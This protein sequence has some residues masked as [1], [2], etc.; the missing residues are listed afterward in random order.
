MAA[1]F[2]T[3]VGGLAFS[4]YSLLVAQLERD[5]K[6]TALREEKDAREIS[7]NVQRFLTE[8]LLAP[9]P[10]R[11]G[12]DTTIREAL[13][14]AAT[15]VGERFAQRPKIE[16]ELRK[17][18]GQ[19]YTTLL[20][21]EKAEVETT[22]QLA[23]CRQLY[24]DDQ[25]ETLE[26]LYSLSF[27]HLQLNQAEL[28]VQESRTTLAGFESCLAPDDPR[29][30][31]A[32]SNLGLAYLRLGKFAEGEREFLKAIDLRS[33]FDGADTK[34]VLLWKIN[35]AYLYVDMKRF[36]NAEHLLRDCLECVR[37]TIGPDHPQ[38]ATI[39]DLLGVIWM[40]RRPEDADP[41]FR[42]SYRVRSKLFGKDNEITLNTLN[43]VAIALSKMDRLFEAREVI[44]QGLNESSKKFGA[45]YPLTRKFQWNLNYVN[46]RISRESPDQDT[47][48]EHDAGAS[49]RVST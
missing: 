22:R 44:L 27:I 46:E 11:M 14:R 2:V 23:L 26:A 18:I 34:E 45:S 1:T 6:Q 4:T 32:H 9:S 29:I 36:L 40:E 15:F 7:E 38:T 16:A 20:E 42:E 8:M 48:G 47:T 12:G 35:L 10:D 49:D 28:A 5:E 25:L 13:N 21:F 30:S 3:L 33:Q 39:V 41:L 17:A 43:N 19:T 24:G 37:R 31:G